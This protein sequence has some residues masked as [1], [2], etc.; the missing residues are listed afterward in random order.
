MSKR[1][2]IDTGDVAVKARSRPELLRLP[3][4]LKST[5]GCGVKRDGEMARKRPAKAYRFQINGSALWLVFVGPVRN[6]GE[7][8]RVLK[9]LF[10][11][12]LTDVRVHPVSD[13]WSKTRQNRA[14]SS[15]SMLKEGDHGHAA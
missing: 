10:G 9:A 6:R 14:T 8:T 4:T 3:Y 15:M 11:N 7:A 13:P 12:R 1:E 2:R 5:N